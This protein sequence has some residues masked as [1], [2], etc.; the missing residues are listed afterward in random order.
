MKNVKLDNVM[1]AIGFSVFESIPIED[2]AN[3]EIRQNINTFLSFAV[4]SYVLV[5]WPE[6]QEYMDEDWFDEEAV[7]DVEG[8]FGSSAY[9]VPLKRL[10]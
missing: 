9:F 10:L 5:Q 8:K 4:D 2:T 1:D 7:L 6:S 3:N